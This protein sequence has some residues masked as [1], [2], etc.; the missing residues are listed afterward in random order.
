M[1]ISGTY[2]QISSENVEAYMEALGTVYHSA[3][4]GT[5]SRDGVSLLQLGAV[6]NKRL[7]CSKWWYRT[8]ATPHM[9]RRTVLHCIKNFCFLRLSIVIV[10]LL[11]WAW[12]NPLFWPEQFSQAIYGNF[13]LAQ[14]G[15]LFRSE[16]GTITEISRKFPICP[17]EIQE[18]SGLGAG[19]NRLGPL[20]PPIKL[21][22]YTCVLDYFIS[23]YEYAVI[24]KLHFSDKTLQYWCNAMLFIVY[25][26]WSSKYVY[27]TVQV[28]V[29][30]F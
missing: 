15:I 27:L 17:Q 1:D 10:I 21:L 25:N 12:N 7:G 20:P 19:R 14:A 4:K 29:L 13:A 6:L 22:Y 30:N 11:F 23:T 5:E 16:E 2:R 26:I 3:F 18:I 28:R 9:P 8:A 24:Q